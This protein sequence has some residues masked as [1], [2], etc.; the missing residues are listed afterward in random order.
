[1][2]RVFPPSGGEKERL[3]TEGK[4]SRI[5]G[6]CDGFLKTGQI[7][8]PLRGGKKNPLTEGRIH[9]HHYLK[10]CLISQKALAN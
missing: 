4:L 9:H 5:V 2:D 7:A 8:A 1:M 6:S 10:L 3:E